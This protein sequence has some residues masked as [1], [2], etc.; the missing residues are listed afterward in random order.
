MYG[1]TKANGIEFDACCTRPSYADGFIIHKWFPALTCRNCGEVISPWVW[2]REWVF[3]FFLW[4]FWDGFVHVDVE[5]VSKED[6]E[7]IESFNW[8]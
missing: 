4:P 7:R 5:H 2:L 8:R 6:I 1:K 3:R